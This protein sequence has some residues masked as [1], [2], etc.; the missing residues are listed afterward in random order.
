MPESELALSAEGTW[1]MV[2]FAFLAFIMSIGGIRAAL[3][4]RK[5]KAEDPWDNVKIKS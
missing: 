3:E 4:A 5:M 2:G 1:G